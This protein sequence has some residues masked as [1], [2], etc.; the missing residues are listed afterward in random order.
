MNRKSED[1][2][3]SEV[4]RIFKNAKRRMPLFY[5]QTVG[6]QVAVQFSAVRRK[7]G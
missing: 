6:R 7:S 2:Q 5:S 4:N 3:K 1:D